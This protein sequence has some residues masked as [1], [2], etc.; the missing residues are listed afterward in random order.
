[1]EQAILDATGLPIRRLK[2]SCLPK[3]RKKAAV[4]L[5]A[6]PLK[7]GSWSYPAD[8]I[9]VQV[10]QHTFGEE[11][12]LTKK[13]QDWYQQAIDRRLFLREVALREGTIDNE[14]IPWKDVLH[15]YQWQMVAFG[16]EAKHFINSDD[17]GLGKTLEALTLAED[18]NCQRVLI[19]CPG[20]LKLNWEREILKWIGNDS[21]TYVT[22]G[23]RAERKAQVQTFM[24]QGRFLVVNYEMIRH[25][26]EEDPRTMKTGYP[27]LL[28][29]NWDMIIFDEAHRLKSRDSQWTLGAKHLSRVEHIQLLTGNPIASRPDDIWSLLHILRPEQYTSYWAFIEYY[30]N[31]VD[32]FFGKEIAGVNTSRMPQLQYTLQPHLLRRLKE[33]V[34]PDLPAKIQH[35][36]LV[37]LSG[38]QK[39]F[40]NR[41][42]K[43]CII[44][45]ENGDINLLPSLIEKS[46]R[47]QQAIANPVLLGGKDDS[48]VERT[49]V[50]LLEDLFE[51][52]NKVIV[53]THFVEAA[54]RLEA[55]LSKQY[56]VF[57]VKAE[58]KDYQRDNVVESFKRCEEK[59]V[60]VGTIRTMSEGLNIDEC[61]HIVFCD[62]SWSPLDNEQF[63]DRIHRIT[64]TRIKNYYSIV[65][66][67][68]V[69]EIKEQVLEDKTQA[70]DEILSMKAV[71]AVLLKNSK[72]N[73]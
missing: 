24:K 66:K 32:T 49:C 71:A 58:L 50:D 26:K 3:D 10:L 23:E 63:A 39:T 42:Q 56:T 14:N 35:E 61:D 15:P 67:G 47:L 12:T 43:Q 46:L 37:E 60:L 7:D 51:G 38:T 45:L 59:A 5:G 22:R 28:T 31:M 21:N 69:S 17:R 48:V 9:V 11:L 16:R 19:V 8:D 40:Y 29:F 2:L 65:V 33:D 13:C 18:Q 73:S 34:A 57:R 68:T 52:T 1:M 36:I 72:S 25:K 30:C 6:S 27:E 55:L 53:G 41:L 64:S 20:Y 54:N 4:P 62:K 70:R 44:E